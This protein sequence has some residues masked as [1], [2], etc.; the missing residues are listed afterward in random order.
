MPS[1]CIEV[2]VV[3]EVDEPS[4]PIIPDNGSGKALAAAAGLGALYIITR[5]RS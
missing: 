5:D 2:E 1:A 4:L 3:E